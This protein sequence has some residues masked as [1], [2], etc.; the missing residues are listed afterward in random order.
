[1][2]RY[3]RRI[4]IEVMVGRLTGWRRIAPRCDRCAKTFFAAVARAAT[5]IFW[6]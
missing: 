1:M 3:K 2:R 4:R 6:L 5:V